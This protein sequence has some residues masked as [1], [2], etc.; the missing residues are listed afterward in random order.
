[1]LMCLAPSKKC[2]LNSCTVQVS[3]VML[4]RFKTPPCLASN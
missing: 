4:T 3:A 1:M 2:A